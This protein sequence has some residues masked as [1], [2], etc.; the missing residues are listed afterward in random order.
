MSR[1]TASASFQA[2]PADAPDEGSTSSSQSIEVSGRS[3]RLVTAE[4]RA[5]IIDRLAQRLNCSPAEHR[6]R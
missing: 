4:L 1:S 6:R 3:V 2:T 5:R